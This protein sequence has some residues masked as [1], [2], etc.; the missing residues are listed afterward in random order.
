MSEAQIKRKAAVFALEWER[1]LRT[2]PW[3]YVVVFCKQK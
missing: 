2:L 1:T 3:Q